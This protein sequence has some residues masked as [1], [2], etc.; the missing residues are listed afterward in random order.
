MFR[1]SEL[2]P[3]FS[4]IVR[5]RCT[6]RSRKSE[7]STRCVIVAPTCDLM[8]SPM[9]GSPRSAKRFCQYGSDAINTG[10][11]LMNAQPAS[12]TCSTYHFVAISE[13]TGR[14]D[15]TTS[16]LVDFNADNVVGGAGG[17]GHDLAKIFSQAI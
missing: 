2:P 9:I 16:V 4:C 1:K 10:M 12:S 17:F 14:Y 6:P 3:T 15:T 8:S 11:Q 5:S 7:V 13:P